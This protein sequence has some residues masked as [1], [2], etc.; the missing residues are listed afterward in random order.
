MTYA[1][2]G[3]VPGT[4]PAALV[5]FAEGKGEEGELE[6][7]LEQAAALGRGELVQGRVQ[8]QEEEV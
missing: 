8:V 1:H 6:E 7:E 5:R 2:Q 4:R 3:V